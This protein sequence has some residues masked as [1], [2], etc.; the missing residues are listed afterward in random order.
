MNNQEKNANLMDVCNEFDKTSSSPNNTTFHS[1]N[2]SMQL[3]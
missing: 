2:V 3:Y 1:F